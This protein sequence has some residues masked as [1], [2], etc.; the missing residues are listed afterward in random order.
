MLRDWLER[1]A[2]VEVKCA[3]QDVCV[4]GQDVW[5]KFWKDIVEN[6]CCPYCRCRLWHECHIEINDDEI[7]HHTTSNEQKFSSNPLAHYE[8]HHFHSNDKLPLTIFWFNGKGHWG[9]RVV[10]EDAPW[11]VNGPFSMAMP[12]PRVDDE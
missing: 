2:S 4:D 5:K 6:V 1:Y 3:F 8:C 11:D 7:P 12:I 10:T 9:V